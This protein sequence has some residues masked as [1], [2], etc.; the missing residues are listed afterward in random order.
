MKSPRN[1]ITNMSDP[2]VYLDNA[3]TTFIDPQV[4]EA[5]KSIWDRRLGNA[6]SIHQLG[7]LAAAE[8]E[9]ARLTIARS[10]GAKADEVY[11]TSGGTESN[12]LAIIGF[13]GA[14]TT[15]SEKFACSVIEHSSV[16]KTEWALKKMGVETLKINVDSSGAIELKSLEDIL[17]HEPMMIS[18]MHANNEVG[19][20]QNLKDIS[21]RCKA[22]NV[23]LHVDACQSYTKVPLH[24]KDMGIDVLSICA[25]KVHGP[26]GVGA[27]YIRDGV[28]VDPILFG[29][30]QELGLRPGTQNVEAVVG[31]SKAVQMAP[32]P[33]EGWKHVET[34]RNDCALECERLGFSVTAKGA[35][36]LPNHLHISRAGL[37]ARR[38]MFE[39]SKR[40]IFVSLG[41]ACN[42]NQTQP[43]HVL[44]A[45]G[46]SPEHIRGSLRISLSKMT[47][48]DEI[49]HFIEV[50]GR[51]L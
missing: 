15:K 9:K 50:L 39:L 48:K 36:R 25:H 27:I 44:T 1:S 19:T 5:M 23:L 10:I 35:D 38:L 21:A 20:V 49:D 46:M 22:K 42:A 31:F 24:V 32:M 14:S 29:G 18:V 17:K 8:L 30:G 6:N 12:N 43:S 7:V 45:M 4:V 16:L 3:S 33:G 47:T 37:D 26:R 34:L 40:N 13:F 11:F 28:K 2:Q 41:S 51:C